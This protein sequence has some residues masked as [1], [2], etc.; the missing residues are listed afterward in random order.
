MIVEI[1]RKDFITM[2]INCLQHINKKERL[3][4]SNGLLAGLFYIALQRPDRL[5]LCPEGL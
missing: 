1:M 2:P 3:S 4:R 5:E